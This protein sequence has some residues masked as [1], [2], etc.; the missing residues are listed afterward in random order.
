MSEKRAGI[1]KVGAR[2]LTKEE[3]MLILPTY[4]E[5]YSQI[6]QFRE[7]REFYGQDNLQKTNNIGIIGVRGAGKTSV[8]K[9]IKGVLDQENEKRELKDVI[10]PII[11]PDNMSES[12]TL[13]ATILGMLGEVVKSRIE[14]EKSKHSDCIRRS[15]LREKYDEVVKQYTFIQKEYRDILIHEY[16]TEND[17]VKSS[18]KV[19]N[20]DTEFI[21]KFNELIDVL[22]DVKQRGEALLFL[23]IDDIDLSTHR[24]ADV[25]R[26]LLSYLS[27]ENIV[28]IISGDLETFEEAL[29]IDFL[30]QERVLDGNILNCSMVGNGGGK[31]TVLESKK[32]LAYEYLKKILPPIYRH[33][34]KHWSLEE[35]G[36]YLVSTHGDGIRKGE[37]VSKDAGD[38]LI[39]IQT[40]SN[41]LSEALRDWV[42]PAFFNY[43]EYISSED[44]G[45]NNQGLPY[46][47]HLFD[48]TSRGLNNIYNMLSQLA[49]RRKQ[50]DLKGDYL[51]EKKQLLDTI[52]AS[53]SAYNRYRN[54]IQKDM[55]NVGLTKENSKVFFDNACAII[56]KEK[57]NDDEKKNGYNE[58][59]LTLKNYYIEDPVERF[60]LFILIDFAARLLYENDY[61]LRTIDDENYKRLKKNAVED[62]FFHSV[63]AE[64]V[65]DVPRF[66]VFYSKNT[67]LE[68][69]NLYD[70][71]INF[72][73]KGDLVLNLAYYRNLNLNKIIKLFETEGDK[74]KLNFLDADLQQ[75]C[76]IAFWKAVSSVARVNRV[77]PL[78]KIAGY[79]PTFWKEFAYVQ[80]Q[81]SSSVTQN[82]IIR[83]L[84][85]QC[86][87]VIQKFENQTFWQRQNKKRVL[88]NT[89][90]Q[91]L[92][93][94]GKDEINNEWQNINFEGAV[95]A[96]GVLIDNKEKYKVKRRIKILKVIDSHQLWKKEVVGEVV[97][98]MDREVDKYLL[99]VAKKIFGNNMSDICNL[100]TNFSIDAWEEF[101]KSRDGVSNT[102]AKQTKRSVRNIL[103]DIKSDFE[104]GIPYYSFIEI[105]QEVS[106]LAGNGQVWYGRHE[107]QRL[108]NS[109][110]KSWGMINNGNDGTY[111]YF[112]FLLQSYLRYKVSS[113]SLDDVNQKG[114]LLAQIANTLSKAQ[115]NADNKALDEF[116]EEINRELSQK[117][118]NDEFDELFG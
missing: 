89:I 99:Y 63:V 107:A 65:I 41:F 52:I 97:N 60:S 22:I 66:N 106:R 42:D 92:I 118:N 34:I 16:T 36:R 2:S 15:E 31:K 69:V 108:L 43:T 50:E 30:R 115:E 82:V 25:V 91:L 40:L 29:I 33:I 18:A 111:S 8:L 113:A 85:E 94:P 26:T 7:E 71:N 75:H 78:E 9:T 6:Q 58:K 24:C 74:E 109:L 3:A 88:L 116:I 39:G 110:R 56:Y 35:R 90:T 59:S 55:I 117:I 93:V 14:A 62:L 95:D 80:M 57:K 79:Y 86:E 5:I 27:N 47:Y 84:D 28:T 37:E 102:I 72:L 114:F 87:K 10:L 68:E 61:T 83:L 17:Y 1:S 44:N 112:V 104:H 64:K 51:K 46:T 12:S 13:M 20:S 103:Y 48:N 67:S 23:F 70:V 100:D 77:E 53:K 11:I 32:Q 4:E 38:V 76:I 21:K 49:K 105:C 81:V 98:Y 96:S 19:F 54:E 101:V 45:N 73:S